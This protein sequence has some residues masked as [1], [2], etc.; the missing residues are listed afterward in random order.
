MVRARAR[1]DVKMGARAR[2]ASGGAPA[3]PRLDMVEHGGACS[4]APLGRRVEPA[5]QNNGA[6]FL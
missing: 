6:T 5:L 4:L 3:L 1:V 2:E